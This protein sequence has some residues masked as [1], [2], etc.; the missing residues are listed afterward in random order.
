M[1]SVLLAF[2]ILLAPIAPARAQPAARC[3]PEAAPVI[4]D[5]VAGAIGAF[6]QRQGG[7]PVFGYPIGP[8]HAEQSAAGPLTV[9]LF[10]R[11]RLELHPAN[12]PPYDVLLGRLGADALAAQ[13]R[14]WQ[15]FPK[16]GA[17]AAHRF[18]ETGHAIDARFWPFW[19]AHGLEFDG[20]RGTGFAES[21]A[22]LGMPISEAAVE[23]SPTDGRPYLTQWFERAR[24]EYH[25][26][27]P[28]PADQVQ[29]GLLQREL[30][31]GAPAA[32]N[33]APGG[34]VQASGAQLTRQ[35]QPVLLKG[36]NYYPQWRPWADMWSEWDGP[37][38]ARE[39]RQ[40]R[41]DLGLNALR[42]MVP[43]NFSGK[44]GGGGK[45]APELVARLRELLQI[46]G[47]LDMR[48][49]V[50][51]F[52]FDHDFPAAGSAGEA[53]DL[54]Y[55]RELVPQ[56][57]DDERIAMWD[58]HNEP[59][60]YEAWRGGN[61]A[62]V[63]SWLGRMA[64]A[65]HALAPRQL[66]TV[67]MSLHPN[68]WLAGPDGRRVIDYSDVVSVHN[69]DA[70]TAAR[71]LDEV[72]AHT[73]K[74]IVVEEFGW[75]TGPAC[76]E[77]YTED[78]QLALFRAEMAA[79]RGRASGA[80]AWVLRDFDAGPTFRWD[81]REEH[82]GLYRPDGSLKPAAA[83]LRGLAAPPLPSATT[84]DLALTTTNPQFADDQYAPLP[85][86]GSGHTVKRAF[87]RA[88][89]L[90]GGATSFG[91]PITEA[92]ERPSD[93]VVVQY[94]AGAALEYHPD[95]GL[96][97]RSIPEGEQVMRV[98]QPVA[99][100]VAYAA[101]RSLGA[102]AA[103]RGAFRD[104]YERING[105]WRLGSPLSGELTEMVDGVAT[106]V[107]YFERGRLERDPQSGAVRVGG[108]GAWAWAGQC[109]AH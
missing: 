10:E 88:W 83:E 101:G 40:A 66:V 84:S 7:L 31:G 2:L 5:C 60:Q 28:R 45:L 74:P 39:L 64:D 43:Y 104:F 86:A 78:T 57:A 94:F 17:A 24:F 21:L 54:A 9:Q 97:P 59:D 69:Y 71:Q 16:A 107:Q 53:R 109:A 50:T 87:R 98:V 11:A 35:G 61:A 72:R 13:G 91:P 80:F 68:L 36:A 51:L 55:L 93:G 77:N 42:V 75:P 32:A 52:D 18:A 4:A 22:L 49:I 92:F 1:R 20:R 96:D 37:Q 70:A 44:K 29:L 95:A 25:P 26:E 15:T 58:V 67:G 23:T 56:F 73:A 103:P 79:V 81:S 38:I 108:L 62:E 30:Q 14:D 19:S 41:D 48:L 6:W 89:E 99:L 33:L 47:S 90:F 46:A 27:Q 65:V 102:P 105:A 34:F 63:L 100:G 3:F 85:I 76:V 106:S 12:Q 8:E 82:F